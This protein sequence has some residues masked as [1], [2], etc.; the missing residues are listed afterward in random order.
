MTPPK[1][2]LSARRV[3]TSALFASIAAF[4]VFSCHK[5]VEPPPDADSRGNAG[6]IYRLDLSAFNSLDLA[7]PSA[8]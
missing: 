4:G 6:P 8:V 5:P 7:N 1:T 3:L 2:I